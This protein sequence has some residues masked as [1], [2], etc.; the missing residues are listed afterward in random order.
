[1][2][3]PATKAD[4]PALLSLLKQLFSIEVDFNFDTEKQQRGLSLLLESENAI[5]FAAEEESGVVGMVTGQ[6]VISTAEGALSLIIED[7][8]VAPA[9]QNRGY[10]S[11]LLSTLAEWASGRG[12]SRMQL[13]ADQTNNPA[14]EFYVGTK[15]QRTQLI[16]M[17]KYC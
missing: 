1:M 8:V 12:A 15:W 3:R 10:G 16:C 7:L 17:R 4:I 13:L 5:I 6:L 14:I 9:M 2:I 11:L